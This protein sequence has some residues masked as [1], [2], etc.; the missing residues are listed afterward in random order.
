MIIVY[1]ILT[2]EVNIIYQILA[3]EVIIVYHIIATEMIIVYQFFA[4][5]VII[6]YHIFATE[7]DLLEKSI[8]LNFNR[9]AAVRVE[10]PCDFVFTR[11]FVQFWNSELKSTIA[12]KNQL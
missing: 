10:A 6:I 8:F 1:H 7:V 5:E 9:A 11:G 4:T 2:T 12:N 3:T